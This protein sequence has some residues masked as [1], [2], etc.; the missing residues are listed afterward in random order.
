M[1]YDF[2]KVV[3]RTGNRA[4]KYDERTKKFG[5]DQVIPLW[6]ADMDFQTAQPIICLLYTSSRPGVL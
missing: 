2:D 1:K 6:I 5:T 3:D 4:A